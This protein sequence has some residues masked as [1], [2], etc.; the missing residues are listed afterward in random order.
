M[1]TLI[2]IILMAMAKGLFDRITLY[3]EQFSGW[4]L[5]SNWNEWP[6][7]KKLLPMF[8]D[9]WHLSGWLVFAFAYCAILSVDGEWLNI[10]R[11]IVVAIFIWGYHDIILKSRLKG[12][13]RVIC[14]KCG[15]EKVEIRPGKWQCEECD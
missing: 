1:Q 12:G 2:F 7:W 15:K 3:P 9:G 10:P 11:H 8:G 14:E 6:L 5:R 4:W 13:F